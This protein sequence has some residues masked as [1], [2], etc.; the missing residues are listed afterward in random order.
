MKKQQKVSKNFRLN[1]KT[2]AALEQYA[3]EEGITQ[4]EALERSIKLLTRTSSAPATQKDIAE[5]LLYI[6]KK[7]NEQN[8]QLETKALLI[9]EKNKKKNWLR[10]LFD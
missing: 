7:F 10:K 3:K 9:E 6:D 1:K 8:E 5:L 2:S 4:T